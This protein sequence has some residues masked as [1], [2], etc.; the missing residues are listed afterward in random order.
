M[1]QRAGGDG[2]EG[3]EGGKGGGHRGTRKQGTRKREPARGRNRGGEARAGAAEEG[4]N[5]EEEGRPRDRGRG[6]RGEK[7][8]AKCRSSTPVRNKEQKIDRLLSFMFLRGRR[9]ARFVRPSVRL[10]S[11]SLLPPTPASPFT[12]APTVSRSS[13]FAWS[14]YSSLSFSLP[15]FFSSRRTIRRIEEILHGALWEKNHGARRKT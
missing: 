14:T 15:L 7:R 13:S 11:L 12:P 2:G 4:G 6:E 3:G 10:L 5:K 1:K 9:T 8:V